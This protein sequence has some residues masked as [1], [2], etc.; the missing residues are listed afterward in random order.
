M[1]NKNGQSVKQIDAQIAALEQQKAQSLVDQMATNEAAIVDLQAANEAL[2]AE[3]ESMGYEVD[4]APRRGRKPGSKNAKKSAA[5]GTGKTN[6]ND[7][8]QAVLAGNKQGMG[9]AEIAEAVLARGY[10]TKSKNFKM[11]VQNCI[12]IQ[13][14]DSYR[15]ISRGVY[16]NV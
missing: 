9:F 16:A 6:L 2:T 4:E 11:V 5:T 3:I 8:I 10:E 15:K 14:K 7:H 12:G 1:A 13:H